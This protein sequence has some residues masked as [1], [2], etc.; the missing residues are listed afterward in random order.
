MEPDDGYV[1]HEMG[2][3]ATDIRCICFGA[4]NNYQMPITT[5]T[6]AV[7]ALATLTIS[8]SFYLG[9]TQNFFISLQY[10]NKLQCS[11]NTDVFF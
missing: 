5:N 2:P 10:N 11:Q 1:G 8:I 6:A 4:I 9:K 7:A 3:R